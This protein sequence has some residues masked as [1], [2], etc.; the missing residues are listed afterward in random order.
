[1]GGGAGGW[2]ALALSRRRPLRVW[3]RSTQSPKARGLEEKPSAL[4]DFCNFSIK[5]TQ[6]YVYFGQN[7][8]MKQ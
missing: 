8:Y 1:M 4:G 7:S 2:R 3:G 6:F 5:T